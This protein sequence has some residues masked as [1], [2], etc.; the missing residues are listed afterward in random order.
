MIRPTLTIE[1]IFSITI[2]TEF[3]ATYLVKFP[4]SSNNAVKGKL[5]HYR[6]KRTVKVPES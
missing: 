1:S 3:Y 2:N 5:S 4:T 6:P